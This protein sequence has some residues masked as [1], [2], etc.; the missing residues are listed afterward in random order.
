MSKRKSVTDRPH[1]D[2]VDMEDDGSGDEVGKGQ[3]IK[4]NR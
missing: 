4:V 2:P 3:R 1:N